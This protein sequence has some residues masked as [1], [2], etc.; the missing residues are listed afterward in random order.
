M[1]S[2]NEGVVIVVVEA[3]NPIESLV[4]VLT[5]NV[6]PLSSSPP[7]DLTVLAVVELVVEIADVTPA[8]M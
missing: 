3:D 5:E 2:P 4:A 7:P 8:S 6:V 1:N